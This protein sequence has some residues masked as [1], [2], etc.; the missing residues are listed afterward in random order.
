MI[1]K[2]Q[3]EYLRLYQSGATMKEIARKYC[4]A[5]STVSRVIKRAKR[6]K[7]P[8]SPKCTACPLDECAIDD[9]YAFMLNTDEDFRTVKK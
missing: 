9:R 6:I 1:T 5:I 3:I 8:F 4:V 7:C 2:Q